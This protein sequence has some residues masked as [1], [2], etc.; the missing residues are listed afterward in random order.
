MSSRAR[1][2]CGVRSI[3]LLSDQKEHQ[4]TPMHPVHIHHDPL[5]SSLY[6]MNVPRRLTH[7]GSRNQGSWDRSEIALRRVSGFERNKPEVS[8][9]KKEEEMEGFDPFL[10]LNKQMF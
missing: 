3:P 9:Y 6:R 5:P 10:F 7:C 4:P 8:E 2:G 1:E